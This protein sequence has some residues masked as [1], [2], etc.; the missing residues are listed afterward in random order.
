M[1]QSTRIG[2][3]GRL[4][5]SIRHSTADI[6]QRTLGGNPD[7]SRF[8]YRGIDHV[9]ALTHED[10]TVGRGEPGLQGFFESRENAPDRYPVQKL[11]SGID[12]IG[13]AEVDTLQPDLL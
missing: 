1:T 7:L 6:S 13:I 10:D 8:P 2:S 11:L 12:K 9:R 3:L 4:A 5:R